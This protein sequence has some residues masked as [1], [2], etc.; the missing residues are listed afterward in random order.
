MALG[1]RGRAWGPL[2]PSGR[3]CEEAD[4]AA[5]RTGGSSGSTRRSHLERGAASGREGHAR[6][7]AQRRH[8]ARRDRG[9]VRIGRA[10]V[11]FAAGWS[12]RWRAR[13]WISTRSIC[14]RGAATLRAGRRRRGRAGAAEDGVRRR[15]L[16]L[17]ERR[18]TPTEAVRR[19]GSLARED[20]GA[21]PPAGSASAALGRASVEIENGQG[22]PGSCASGAGYRVAELGADGSRPSSRCRPKRS[23]GTA[24]AA[25]GARER[26]AAGEVRGARRR[27]AAVATAGI[28][29]ERL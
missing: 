26:G 11:S 2:A 12:P 8:H 16:Q 7:R 24:P 3:S 19:P 23:D 21:Q 29:S 6:R 5:A 22:S 13:R 10:T 28:D 27:G 9:R 14:W 20:D 25:C 17:E 18:A 1:G 4:R 15:A